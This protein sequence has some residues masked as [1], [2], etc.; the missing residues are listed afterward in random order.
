MISDRP[1]T[2][3]TA[4]PSSA[5]VQAAPLVIECA[6]L[7]LAIDAM[8]PWLIQIRKAKREPIPSTQKKAEAHAG[9]GE[10]RAVVATAH[11]DGDAAGDADGQAGEGDDGDEDEVVAGG[12]DGVEVVGDGDGEDDDGADDRLG[13]ELA[14]LELEQDEEDEG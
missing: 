14:L 4:I 1:R 8:P 9:A 10:D 7:K 2:S 11:L 12:G 13:G 5:S 3:N 6:E